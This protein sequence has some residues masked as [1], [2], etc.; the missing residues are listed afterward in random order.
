[1]FK[2]L[3]KNLTKNRNTIILVVI[4]LVILGGLGYL[5]YHNQKEK[6]STLMS[7]MGENKY[8][9]LVKELGPQCVQCLSPF[10]VKYYSYLKSENKSKEE[11]KLQIENLMKDKTF[12]ME[13]QNTLTNCEVCMTNYINNSKHRNIVNTYG[14]DCLKCGYD[15][16][17][18]NLIKIQNANNNKDYMEI[19][20]LFMKTCSMCNLDMLGSSLHTDFLDHVNI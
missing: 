8:N 7:M 2:N 17:V 11:H 1:M 15:Y 19:V 14:K 13:L 12:M 9:N 4:S 3:T 16:I 6:D 10:L 20:M 5:Y 18:S